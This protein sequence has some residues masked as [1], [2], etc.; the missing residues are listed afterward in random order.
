MKQ[1]K[2]EEMSKTE[3]LIG[4]I[5]LAV[6]AFLIVSIFSNFGSNNSSNDQ[7][8][9]EKEN[10][11][12]EINL[13]IS[14]NKYGDIVVKVLNDIDWSDCHYKINNKFEL[15]GAYELYSQKNLSKSDIDGQTIATRL[16]TDKDGLKFNPDIYA[17]KTFSGSC[18][19]PY[20]SF[21]YYE[22]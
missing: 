6:F 7:S 9:P 15:N 1:K 2:W 17:V 12:E 5:S 14:K 10:P 3:K 20:Y 13:E 8:N 4:S 21:F 11:K 22:K 16:F 19:Q 18:Q